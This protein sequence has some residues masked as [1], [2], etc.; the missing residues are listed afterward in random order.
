MKREL[1]VRKFTRRNWF[2]IWLEVGVPE[3]VINLEDYLTSGLDGVVLNIDELMAFLG[4]FDAMSEEVSF[5]KKDIR[6]LALFLGD[7][8]KVLHR[9]KIP[10]IAYGKMTLDSRVLD[11]LVDMGVY[12]VVVERY[13]ADSAREYLYQVEKKVILRRSSQA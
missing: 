4:G 6:A 8:L 11:F 13:E 2:K 3:N 5:Y 10:F 7:G 12:G 9:A 1:A